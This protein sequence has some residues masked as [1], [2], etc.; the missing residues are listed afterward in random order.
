M[1]NA[2]IFTI[3]GFIINYQLALL[4]Y[5]KT[6]INP[7]GFIAALKLNKYLL[8]FLSSSHQD[9]SKKWCSSG[10]VSAASR[11]EILD[12]TG[13]SGTFQDIAVA[14]E[15][16]TNHNIFPPKILRFN[17]K[18]PDCHVSLPIYFPAYANLCPLTPG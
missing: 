18:S 7:Y 3:N 15:K 4:E 17:I 14:D 8:L 5:K 6:V 16:Y 9:S 12:F 2:S 10:V 1:D 11:H 13:F